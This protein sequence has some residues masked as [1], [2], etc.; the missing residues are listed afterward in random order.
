MVI[1]VGFFKFCCYCPFAWLID[2]PIGLHPLNRQFNNKC[3]SGQ[4]KN[5]MDMCLKRT[6]FPLA[7]VYLLNDL[8]KELFDHQL[9]S[10]AWSDMIPKGRGFSKQN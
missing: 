2:I 9:C 7:A 3:S 10:F 4:D 6:V 1:N 8:F 5:Q